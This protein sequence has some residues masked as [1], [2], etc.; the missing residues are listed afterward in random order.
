MNPVVIRLLNQQLAAPRFSRPA[1][2]VSHLCA[3]QAQEYRMMR[4]AVAMR[5]KK[6]SAKAFREAFDIGNIIRLHLMRGT[7]QL[8]SA[9][10]YWWMLELFSPRAI[11]VTNGW[12]S[13]NGISIT[14]KEYRRIGDILYRIAE[15]KGS[16]T[17]EDIKQALK[18]KDIAMD[19]HRLSYHIRMAEFTGTLCSGDLLP[20]KATYALASKKAGPLPGR[21]DRDEALM[22]LTRRFFRSRQPATLE[23]FV[24]WSGLNISDCRRGIKLLNTSIHKEHINGRDFY[25]TDDCRTRGFRSGKFLLIPPYD[26]Y[27]IGYKSRDIVLPQEHRHKAHNNSGIFQPIIAHDGLICGNWTPFKPEFQAEF[28]IPSTPVAKHSS[29]TKSYPESL[30]HAWQVYN[31]FRNA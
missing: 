31:R 2:V 8:V 25:L 24:W 14:E 3:I 12:M 21:T 5:T 13:S 15:E 28:F 17:K 6:P 16:V 9:Q 10:D 19:D 11:A 7:W 1:E 18:E 29:S 22:M 26:E 4:W 27:L 30:Q 20:M 23:D